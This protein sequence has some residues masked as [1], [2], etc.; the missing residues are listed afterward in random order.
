[1]R[2][3]RDKC[4]KYILLILLAVLFENLYSQE[5]VYNAKE[6]KYWLNAGGGG[7][8]FGLSGGLGLSYQRG[9][10]LFSFRFISSSK[11]GES[12]LGGYTT[13]EKIG[14]IGPLYGLI[15][16]GKLGYTSISGG[17]SLVTGVKRG[18]FLGIVNWVNTYEKIPIHTIGLPLEAQFFFTP[19]SFFGIGTNVFRKNHSVEYYFVSNLGN[20]DS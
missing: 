15:I 18:E 19:A 3:T 16:K 10:N 12:Y 7:S 17:V 13:S 20:S 6:P 5:T 4:L 8:S 1:M 2:L 9:K 11:G 14:D